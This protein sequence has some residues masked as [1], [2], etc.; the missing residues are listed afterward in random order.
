MDIHSELAALRGK[1]HLAQR[2]LEERDE[3]VTN[4]QESLLRLTEEYN[5]LK[6]K[7]TALSSVNRQVS[8]R[9]ES[10]NLTLQAVLKEKE[11]LEKGH[12]PARANG[13]SE[14]TR[15]GKEESDDLLEGYQT[16]VEQQQREIEQLTQEL[17]KARG[18][19]RR[20]SLL[21]V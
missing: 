2:R 14:S 3:L 21:D 7:N 17:S 5:D 8:D 20:W 6:E 18:T 11:A 1:L 10:T 4:L 19:I 12:A 13:T 16:Q 15:E 9:L